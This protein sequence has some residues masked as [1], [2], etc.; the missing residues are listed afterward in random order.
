[1]NI[2]KLPKQIKNKFSNVAYWIR[3]SVGADF[4][5]IISQ[6]SNT[7]ESN[8]IDQLDIFHYNCD[9]SHDHWHGASMLPDEALCTAFHAR[10]KE[11]QR[12]VS[13]Q[14]QG[15]L[16]NSSPKNRHN[17]IH[18]GKNWKR[19][20]SSDFHCQQTRFHLRIFLH[21]MQSAHIVAHLVLSY[22]FQLS[23][24]VEFCLNTRAILWQQQTSV[25]LSYYSA[26]WKCSQ[27]CHHSSIYNRQFGTMS[28]L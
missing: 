24:F 28:P 16:A 27:W 22:L 3:W 25:P 6:K 17:I 11:L 18:S 7:T 8:H 2:E 12:M 21:S 9:V 13:S 14:L 23:D 26:F 5:I 4:K 15:Y 1:M 10:N 20:M 19:N